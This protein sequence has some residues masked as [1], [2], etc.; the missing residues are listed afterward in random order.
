MTVWVIPYWI[1]AAQAAMLAAALWRSRANA[2]AN[3]VLAGWL[4]IIALDLAVKAGY[5]GSA[6]PALGDA[7]RIA[8]LLPLIHAPMFFVY[9]RVLTT[10]RPPRW[11]DL[12]HAVWFGLAL[13]WAGVRWAGGTP[14]SPQGSWD[15]AWFDPLLYLVAFAY[16]AAALRCVARYRRGLKAQRSDA[17]RL[18]L[19]WL[20]ALAAG[21]FVIWGIAL[22][23]W[24]VQLPYLDYYLIYGAVA[25][26]VCVIGWFSLSQPP[27]AMIGEATA[28][29]DPSANA[30]PDHD[31][32]A[33]DARVDDVEARLSGLMA[34][35]RL[36]REPALT[37][38]QL[39]RRS[40][41]P[42]YLVSAVINRRLGGNFWEYVN[43]HRIEAVRARLA[44][45]TESRAILEL[46]YDAGFTSKSTFNTAFKR[47]VG[48]TPSAFRRRHAAPEPAPRADG[49]TGRASPR[50]RPD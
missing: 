10:G 25:A 28:D 44:D 23:Q 40:G 49:A 30:S 17:D 37:I 12:G 48:E 8:R 34:R 4:G 38:A 13:A 15:A 33:G 6:T 21:Q 45:P 46:A 20:T 5:I 26:W 31:G 7:Y 2:S 3:R 36:Y 32:L 43:R 47:L 1:G 27:V 24:L 50:T 22:L 9:V 11:R 29:A 14:L 39:A 41:Y 19:R 35:E 18:S 42:E 16:L